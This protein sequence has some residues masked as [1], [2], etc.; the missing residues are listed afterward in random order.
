M[1]LSAKQREK[2]LTQNQ[3]EFGEQY[4]S[5]VFP[6]SLALKVANQKR[7]DYLTELQ[8]TAVFGAAGTKLNMHRLSPGCRICTEGGWSCLFINGKCN[9]RCFY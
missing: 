7:F 8:E 2:I 4:L 1:A 6:D 9:C 5:L 3:R